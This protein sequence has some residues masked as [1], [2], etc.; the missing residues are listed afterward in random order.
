MALCSERK[1]ASSAGSDKEVDEP[2]PWPERLHLTVAGVFV[3]AALCFV[4]S[5]ASCSASP[6]LVTRVVDG[7][8]IDIRMNGKDERVRFLC[9]NTPESVHPDN[10]RN[11]P[12]GR[13]ASRYTKSR[14]AGKRVEIEFEGRKRGRYGRLLAYVILDG[15]N[16]N[17]EL[18][19]RGVSP[20]YTKYGESLAYDREFKN[21][22]ALAR[23]HGLHIWNRSHPSPTVSK[24][25]KVK[26]KRP[27][28]ENLVFHGNLNSRVFHGPG[29][30]YYD[31]KNCTGIFFSRENA[32]KSGYR[33]CR[34]CQP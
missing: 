16:F 32:K 13:T 29:C 25:N 28:G 34:V 27:G 22:Q 26:K 19:R 21:A 20:Y 23:K 8:T 18:V 1:S 15:R 33:P 17:V 31:C 2:E 5:C 7:D 30:R 12:M 6:F 9:V 14:L 11:G 10:S 4:F 24:Q 3:L